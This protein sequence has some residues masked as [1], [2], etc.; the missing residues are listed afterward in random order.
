MPK[1]AKI[2]IFVQTLKEGG[3]LEYT[4]PGHFHG[5]VI[6]Q[7]KALESTQICLKIPKSV[8]E[9]PKLLQLSKY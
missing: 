9:D 5:E 6:F 8:T 7:V 4:E 1:I 2:T 3:Y